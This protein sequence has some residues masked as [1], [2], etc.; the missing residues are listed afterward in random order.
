[1]TTP[2]LPVVFYT[3]N[4]VARKTGLNYETIRRHVNAGTLL[5]HKHDG[6]WLVS[7][8]ALI[9]WLRNRTRNG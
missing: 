2:T 6:T 5:A 3:L 4:E 7:D 9:S 1:M 8:D